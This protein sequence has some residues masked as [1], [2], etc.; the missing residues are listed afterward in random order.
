MINQAIH[1]VNW[2]VVLATDDVNDQVSVFNDI[3]LN[4]M[5]NFIPHE[6]I[7]CDD[8]DPP[9]VNNHI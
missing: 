5:K 6:K 3:I 1:T 9:W 4:V 7:S 8:R 2:D